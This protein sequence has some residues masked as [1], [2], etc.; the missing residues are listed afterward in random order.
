MGPQAQ[1]QGMGREGRGGEGRGGEGRR[2][3]GSVF[4]VHGSRF[5]IRSSRFTVHDSQFTVHDSRKVRGEIRRP[6]SITMDPVE[7]LRDTVVAFR[8]QWIHQEIL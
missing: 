6:C 2:A 1:G 8:F 4:I 3:H 7:P 5:T